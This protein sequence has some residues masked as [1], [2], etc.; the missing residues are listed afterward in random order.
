MFDKIQNICFLL[1]EESFQKYSNLS[2]SKLRKI[3][4]NLYY[5]PP[6]RK[7]SSDQKKEIELLTS[8]YGI[9]GIGG[10]EKSGANG[11]DYVTSVYSYR[12]EGPVLAKYINTLAAE[13]GSGFPEYH[14]EYFIGHSFL[15]GVVLIDRQIAFLQADSLARHYSKEGIAI[16]GVSAIERGLTNKSI[17][18]EIVHSLGPKADQ[19]DYWKVKHQTIDTIAAKIETTANIPCDIS[20]YEIDPNL[21]EEYLE[22]CSVFESFEK[23]IDFL[24]KRRTDFHKSTD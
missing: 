7:I 8:K 9:T 3:A 22:V 12:K 20:I 15:Y 10:T 24:L 4:R 21:K 11:L 18:H 17:I 5:E 6:V 19:K 14:G 1:A 23:D 2:L 16:I 13:L